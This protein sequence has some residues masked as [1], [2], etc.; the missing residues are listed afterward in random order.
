MQMR[1]H[2]IFTASRRISP[3][4]RIAAKGVDLVI[5][6]AVL[7]VGNA[8]FYPLGVLLCFF[9]LLLQ[10][11][12]GPSVGKRLFGLRV[13][14]DGSDAPATLAQSGLRNVPFALGILFGAIAAFWVFFVLIFVP[15]FA[16]ELYFVARLDSGARLGDV[17]AGT[18]VC[19]KQRQPAPLEISTD[20]SD[21]AAS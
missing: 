4:D 12:W 21:S 5:A 6:A 13:L 2:P 1:K 18:Y 15:L 11:G 3:V 16:L 10:D 19:D 14:Q 7:S 9:F 17:L 8:V 20:D